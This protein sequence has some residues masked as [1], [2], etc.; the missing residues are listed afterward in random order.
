MLQMKSLDARPGVKAPGGKL[1]ARARVAA[2][3]PRLDP[4]LIPA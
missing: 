3:R 2:A 4:S 1:H